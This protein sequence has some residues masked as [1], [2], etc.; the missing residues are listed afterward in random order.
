MTYSHNQ[1]RQ[2]L[3]F[4]HQVPVLLFLNYCHL[5]PSGLV[6]QP[7]NQGQEKRSKT[8]ANKKYQQWSK[9]LSKRRQSQ[10]YRNWQL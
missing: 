4:F 10:L 9:H 5:Q 7:G 8:T 3:G 1:Q 2:Y 6:S